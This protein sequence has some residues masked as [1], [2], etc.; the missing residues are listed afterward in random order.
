M[1]RGTTPTLTFA[2]PFDTSKI[3]DGYVTFAQQKFVIIDKKVSDCELDGNIINL[4]L[5]QEETLK[6][7][8]ESDVEIQ[9][10]V[11]ID[12]RRISSN[13]ITMPVNRVLHG[14]VI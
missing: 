13:I 11:K 8:T 12:D 10:T 3:T 2:I 5:T 9:I 4:T 6:F 14:G 7:Q 1:I